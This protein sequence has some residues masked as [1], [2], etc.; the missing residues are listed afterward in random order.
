MNKTA[1]IVCNAFLSKAGPDKKDALVRFLPQSQ[2]ELL[3]TLATPEKDPLKASFDSSKLLQMVHP[4]WFTSFLRSLPEAEVRLFLGSFP[5]NTAKKL[6]K[7]L[8]FSRPI[9]PLTPLAKKYLQSLLVQQLQSGHPDL[10]LIEL[11]P[12][13]ALNTLLDV[14]HEAM[15]LLVE[16]LGLHDLAVEIRQIIDTMKLKKIHSVLSPDQEAYLKGLLQKKEAVLF[17]RMELTKWDGKSESLEKVLYHRGLNRL[18]KALYPENT[19]LLWYISHML[20]W[21]EANSLQSL[22]KPLEHAKAAAL[23]SHQILEILPIIQNKLS[24]EGS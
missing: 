19:S 1:W 4:S 22:C 3:T 15:Q 24:R 6:Q 7:A 18:A 13:S 11:L 16:Y 20:P 5:E 14:S 17:K 2:Q 8:L 23:L 9:L 21:E 12:H 10:L